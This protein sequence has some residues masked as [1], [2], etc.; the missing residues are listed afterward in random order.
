MNELNELLTEF[1]YKFD[2][3]SMYTAWVKEYIDNVNEKYEDLRKS[4]EIL[5]EQAEEW[6]KIHELS[7]AQKLIQMIL[8]DKDI[9]AE[10]K[11]KVLGYRR[12]L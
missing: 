5:K 8:K 10:V 7:I 3:V 6:E 4:V 11:T 1:K 12:K 2:M 9:P